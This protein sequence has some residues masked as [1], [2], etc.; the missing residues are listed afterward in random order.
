MERR[1]LQSHRSPGGR[2]QPDVGQLRMACSY[3]VGRVT[4]RGDIKLIVEDARLDPTTDP[5]TV[6]AQLDPRE[7]VAYVERLGFR[8]MKEAFMDDKSDFWEVDNE[9]EP[10]ECMTHALA[11]EEAIADHR[12]Q[13]QVVRMQQ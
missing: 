8:V 13:Q 3:F 11:Q 10:E 9:P 12:T 5:I 2:P 6:L 7:I 1:S 4:E